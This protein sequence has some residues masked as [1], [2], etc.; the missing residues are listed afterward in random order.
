MS[1]ELFG[2]LVVK[3]AVNAPPCSQ[4]PVRYVLDPTFHFC[5]S[6]YMNFLCHWMS[7]IKHLEH[8]LLLAVCLNTWKFCCND[9]KSGWSRACP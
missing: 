8:A 2:G 9:E 5:R 7:S 3:S 4:A 1:L 6:T